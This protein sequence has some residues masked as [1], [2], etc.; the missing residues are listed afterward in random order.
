MKRFI[1]AAV[2]FAAALPFS[3]AADRKVLEPLSNRQYAEA[4][5]VGNLTNPELREVSGMTASRRRPDILWVANDSG[6]GTLLYAIGMDGRT[7]GVFH[8]KGV[9]NRD[10]EDLA[11]FSIGGKAHL[12]IADVG[13]NNA[14]RQESDLYIV[15]EPV[16]SRKQATTRTDLPLLRRIRFVYEDGPRDCEAVAVDL[17]L[18]R[19]LLLSKRDPLP[20]L[21]ALP[22]WPKDETSTVIARFLVEISNIP[23][24][25]EEDLLED[26]I[27][28]RFASQPTAM[29]IDPP[30]QI[31]VILTYNHAYLYERAPSERWETA[32]S[33]SPQMLKLP[34]LKQAEALC[35]GYDSHTIFVTSE[36]RPPSEALPAPLLRIEWINDR[37]INSS[38]TE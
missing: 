24:P 15:E 33:R 13:D 36:R 1:L 3:M 22:L 8:V 17:S 26:P 6:N 12:L 10:W 31:A 28:G 19:V 4:R 9:R 30:G 5:Q 11:S 18:N 29:D 7:N 14:K 37:I 38:K 34:K 35:I 2:V 27:F 21:Y 23:L 16:L 25:T 20:R 32:F